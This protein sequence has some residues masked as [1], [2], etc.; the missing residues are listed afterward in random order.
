M[1]LVGKLRLT[2]A[3]AVRARA[4][5]G[6]PLRAQ[7]LEMLRLGLGAARLGPGDYYSYRLFE[8]GLSLAQKREFVGWRRERLLDALNQ[9]TWHCLG[10]DKVLMTE[11]MSAQG[12]P[13]TETRAVY[14]RGRE[15]RLQ[16]AQALR[17][18]NELAGWLREPAHYPFFAK[19][20]ASGF[21]RG[22]VYALGYEP[23][24]DS[25]RLRNGELLPLQHFEAPALDR[26]QLGYLFQTPL[27]TDPRLQ[28]A[29]GELP[30]SLRVMVLLD[31]Q[32]GPLIHRCFWKLPVGAN[33]HDNFND[34]VTGNL[35]AGVDLRSGRVLRAINGSGLRL[36]E[37]EQHPDSGARLSDLRVPDWA[38]VQATV[39]A[40]ALLF[41]RLGFQQWDIALTD[42]GPVGMEL[43]LFGTGG[44]ELSQL[45]ERRG[46]LDATLRGFLRR[47]GL[48]R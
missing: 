13:C 41:P 28:V 34:G 18:P 36:R 48:L 35:A 6:R 45:I 20:A 40:L 37:V 5:S 44:C 42:Q 9:P 38:R 4:Q 8:P 26:E 47:Q 25:V 7:A 43:N 14:L 2:Y 12:L 10:L 3:N 33:M 31:G 16:H 46:L 23:A 1:G 24:S 22:A 39:T 29:L 32:Q 17:T 15:R 19:P 11:L 27:R 21:G 30:T